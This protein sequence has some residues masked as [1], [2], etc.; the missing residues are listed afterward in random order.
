MSE[1]LP[2]KNQLPVVDCFH[3]KKP[4]D[5]RVYR[6]TECDGPYHKGCME[7]HAQGWRAIH[8]LP[9]TL[10]RRTPYGQRI[11]CY[12]QCDDGDPRYCH[13]WKGQQDEPP[14][15]CMCHDELPEAEIER[16][17]R[18]RDNA[19]RLAN[20]RLG[21]KVQR[22]RLRAA[23]ERLG[24]MEAFVVSRAV[25][26]HDAELIARI[27]YA[28]EALRGDAQQELCPHGFVLADNICG[29]CS[30]GRANR[31]AGGT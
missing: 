19:E 11:H 13:G 16:L 26:A 30:E 5:G 3:C 29:P 6:C 9:N 27:E 25:T 14:C 1:S 21:Y 10:R 24:S 23:L 2:S 20:L 7:P 18:E 31:T 22:D 17:T 12:C 28:Q 4:I 15:E 8:P